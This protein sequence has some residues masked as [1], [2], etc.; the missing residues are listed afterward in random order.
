MGCLCLDAN[1]LITFSSTGCQSL[2]LAPR[3]MLLV[4]SSIKVR[5][6]PHDFVPSHRDEFALCVC[7]SRAELQ[8]D[9]ATQSYTGTLQPTHTYQPHHRYAWFGS[10][11]NGDPGQL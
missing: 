8:Y 11:E 3:T 6:F 7:M 5:Y 1:K 9:P 10:Q 4:C 2:D